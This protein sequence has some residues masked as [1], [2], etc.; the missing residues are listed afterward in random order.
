MRTH[1]WIR[2]L[3][4]A[5]L[6]LPLAGQAQPDAAAPKEPARPNGLYATFNTSL[7]NITVKL[8]DKE[9]PITVKNFVDLALGRK[10]YTD[11]RTGQKSS[12]P[13]YDGLT[14]HRVIPGFMIQGGDPLGSG[15]GGT[16]P[17]R[18]EFLPGLK[19]EQ[20]GRLA[21]ANRGPDTGSCQFFITEAPTPHLNGAHTIFGQVVEGQDIVHKIATV[22]R[23]GD[24]PRVPV[25]ILKVDIER[26]GPEPGGKKKTK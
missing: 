24:K 23:A 9:T 20:P 4:C 14:F 5:V 8:F 18:D 6:A 21:M 2:T 11:P 15:V 25:R 17:I 10:A 22:D 19:F 13:L 1:V 26:V 7:G 3:A 12:Q 16:E